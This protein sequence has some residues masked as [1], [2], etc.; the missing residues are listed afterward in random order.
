MPDKYNQNFEIKEDAARQEN[1]DEEMTGE[2]LH[3]LK[4]KLHPWHGKSKRDRKAYIED[5]LIKYKTGRMQRE[6]IENA[7]LREQM[8]IVKAATNKSKSKRGGSAKKER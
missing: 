5:M 1:E 4:Y 6:E 3:Q 2:E 7:R 8:G